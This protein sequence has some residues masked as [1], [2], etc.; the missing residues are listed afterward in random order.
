MDKLNQDQIKKIEDDFSGIP[1]EYLEL[2]SINGWGEHES[3]YMFYSSPAY[4]KDIFG[5][6]I[7][8]NI[9]S[10]VL[11]GDDMAGFSIGFGSKWQF[12]GI[13]S[14]DWQIQII[15]EGISAYIKS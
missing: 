6:D 5:T 7:P 14:C 15:S 1:K 13:D 9:Q 2:L 8:N 11:V 12:V 10:V 4:A 3:G